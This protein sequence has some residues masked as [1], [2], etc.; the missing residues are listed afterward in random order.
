M[1]PNL[2]V[3]ECVVTKVVPNLTLCQYIGNIGK[4]Y[5]FFL[6]VGILYNSYKIHRKNR[7]YRTA[8][9]PE[10]MSGLYHSW[11]YSVYHFDQA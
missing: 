10:T 9:I 4:I 11:K 3:V 2:L 8:G 5:I 7:K 1:G 6:I